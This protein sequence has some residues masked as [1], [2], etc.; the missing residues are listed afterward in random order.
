MKK[1]DRRYK[2]NSLNNVHVK[3]IST[4]SKVNLVRSARKLIQVGDNKVA[5]VSLPG[6][7]GVIVSCQCHRSVCQSWQ[8]GVRCQK[9]AKTELTKFRQSVRVK[10]SLQARWRARQGDKII[11][12]KICLD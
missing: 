4:H 3:P 10:L 12:V 8:A 1:K 9:V 2:H 7:Q 6:F 11:I 5:F